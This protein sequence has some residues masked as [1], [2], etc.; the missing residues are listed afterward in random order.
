M[1]NTPLSLDPNAGPQLL[2][3]AA[4]QQP[5]MAAQ[6]QAEAAPEAETGYTVPLLQ[7]STGGIIEVPQDHLDVAVRSGNFSPKKDAEFI[8]LDKYGNRNVVTGEYLQQALKQGML[9]ESSQQRHE[10]E[11]QEQYGDQQIAAG[12]EGLGRGAAA[13]PSAISQGLAAATGNEDLGFT[14]DQLMRGFSKLTGA[15]WTEKEMRDRA[16]ANPISSGIGDIAGQIL[17][18]EGSAAAKGV[19]AIEKQVA[20]T[21]LKD[22]ATAGVSKKIAASLAAKAAG[23][24]VEGAYFGAGQLVTEDSIGKADLN[25]ENLAFAMGTGA[26]IGGA[27]GTAV[28]AAQAA[29]PGVKSLTKMVGKGA[30]DAAETSVDQQVSAARLLGITPNQLAKLEERNPGMVSQMQTYLKDDLQLS[31]TDTATNLAQKNAAISERAGKEISNVLNEMNSGMVSEAGREIM[32]SSKSVW[33]NVYNKVFTKFGD[34]IEAGS[35]GTSSEIRQITKFLDEVYALGKKDATFDASQLQK[36]KKIQDDLINYEKE[37]GKWTVKQEMAHLTRQALK[38]EIDGVANKLDALG[39]GTELADR[40]KAAN[41]QYAASATFGDFIEKKALKNADRDW[42]MLGAIK[43]V[44]LDITRK[45]AVLGKLEGAKQAVGKLIDSSISAMTSPTTQKIAKTAKQFTT[46]SIMDSAFSKR[47][48]DGKYKSPK[49]V[50]E[51]YN[52]MQ[53]NFNRYDNDPDQFMN[54]MN[55]STSAIYRQ[56]PDTS[57]ALDMVGTKAALFLASKIP[58][59]T[60]SPGSSELF[61]PNRPPSRLDLAKFE[62]YLTAVEKPAEV[63]KAM[64]HGRLSREHVE[65]IKSVYP[66]V[67]MQMQDKALEAVKKNP[68]MPYNKKLQIGLL[69]DVPTDESLLPQNVLALQSLFQPQE[70]AQ[71][72]PA[73]QGKP[74][75]AAAKISSS[76]R[77]ATSLEATESSLHS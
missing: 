7:N 62:R 32:P 31:L 2:Q 17:G 11:L 52:N 69:L 45:L 75:P 57:T 36:L 18:F 54:R 12:I 44:G 37:P 25:A 41:R 61:K 35:A 34:F 65:A 49:S 53:N 16:E 28:G 42:S 23:S 40:L 74:N 13:L 39:M 8:V 26:L 60:S 10:R 71:Q 30:I 24:A 38:S 29:L 21:I 43:G 63:F 1:A 9:M 77:T 27:L 19:G 4:A 46:M 76:D 20:K 47:F 50:T 15:N 68:Q 67:Y 55:R 33:D 58:K 56:A 73:G 66:N 6:P 14:P 51:A 22:A 64:E 59:R 5:I 3:Q 72:A 70:D 48:E